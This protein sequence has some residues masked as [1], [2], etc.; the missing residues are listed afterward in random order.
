MQNKNNTLSSAAIQAPDETIVD[1]TAPTP[2]KTPLSDEEKRKIEARIE[3]LQAEIIAETN[4]ADRAINLRIE[5]EDM[6]EK[7]Q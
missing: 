2:T 3:A 6:L 5:L 1:T 7:L 4:D